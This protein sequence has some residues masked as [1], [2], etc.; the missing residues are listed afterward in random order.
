MKWVEGALPMT[1]FR[2]VVPEVD[3]LHCFCCGTLYTRVQGVVNAECNCDISKVC[4]VC[5]RCS[6]HCM[7]EA[8]EKAE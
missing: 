8:E 2:A 3:N 1:N 4:M 5:Q 7:C 6:V